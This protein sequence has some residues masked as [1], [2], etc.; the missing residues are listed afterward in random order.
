MKKKFTSNKSFGVLLSTVLIIFH[1]I[2]FEFNYSIILPI[3]ALILLLSYLRPSFF[4]YPKEIWIK[5]GIIL[6]KFLNP[7][8]CFILYFL[9]IGITKLVLCLFMKKLIQ[10]KSNLKIKSIW[11]LRK[12]DSYL[13]LDNQF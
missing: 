6:G 7:I 5:F 10:K 8:I 2:F 3:A 1:V 13:N 11:I 9:V 4:K 12:D